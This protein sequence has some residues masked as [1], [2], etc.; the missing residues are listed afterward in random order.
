MSKENIQGIYEKQFNF[1]LS[2]L[3][4]ISN[5]LLESGFEKV[6]YSSPTVLTIYFSTKDFQVPKSAYIRVRKYLSL[7]FGNK[8]TLTKD[9]QLFLETKPKDLD[10]RHKTRHHIIYEDLLRFFD[11][12][13]PN[14]N[15]EN[16]VFELL[17]HEL[18][19]FALIP[20]VAT[21]YER[22]HYV[23][24]NTRITLDRDISAFGFFNSSKYI[25]QQ[26]DNDTES[27]KLEIK[28]DSN[29]F[30][31]Q[32]EVSSWISNSVISP[33]PSGQSEKN[34][35]KAYNKVLYENSSSI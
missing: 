3:T 29:I 2:K 9:E 6:S 21:Q 20:Y 18:G 15:I 32:S 35:R 13:N 34:I 10:E 28:T 8:I 19:T 14:F 16:K 12:K 24:D 4:E 22:N 5:Y 7:P 1:Q 27:G 11:G 25:A 17:S 30:S 26:I 23:K 33:T 31:L